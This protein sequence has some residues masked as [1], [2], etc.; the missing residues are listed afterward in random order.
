MPDANIDNGRC[1]LNFHNEVL[2]LPLKITYDATISHRGE[3]CN[4]QFLFYNNEQN[5]KIDSIVCVHVNSTGQTFE[6]N[7]EIIIKEGYDRSNGVWKYKQL[8]KKETTLSSKP[9]E[10][11][12]VT[13]ITDKNSKLLRCGLGRNINLDTGTPINTTPLAI[14]YFSTEGRLILPK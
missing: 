1:V 12:F 13:K 11:S 3:C 10:T 14:T 2:S 7:I 4:F 5:K 6:D 9:I 8:L